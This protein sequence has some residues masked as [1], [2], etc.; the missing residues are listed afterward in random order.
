MNT[1]LWVC[2]HDSNMP[3]GSEVA[4]LDGFRRCDDWHVEYFDYR[5]YR[6]CN[7]DER[8]IEQVIIIK[9][10]AVDA[11]LFQRCEGMNLNAICDH[12]ECPIFYFATES[13]ANKTQHL[14]FIQLNGRVKKVFARKK[15]KEQAVL[16]GIPAED[17]VEFILPFNHKHYNNLKE[18]KKFDLMMSGTMSGRRKG[19][20]NKLLEEVNKFGKAG[21]SQ[22]HSDT[23]GKHYNQ[24][25]AVANVHAY[26][27]LDTE[28]RVFEVMS[29]SAVL[30]TEPLADD[31]DL[32]GK[33]LVFES[34]NVEQC[35]EHVKY[36]KEHEEERLA[37]VEEANYIAKTRS[38]EVCGPLM[39]DIIA[40]SL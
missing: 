19:I 14:S 7:V 31:I 6:Q 39:L 18:E 15:T 1:L 2:C 24:A 30:I 28:T 40:E 26:D 17:V 13:E 21:Y 3:W 38:W 23:L 9:A 5:V 25:L 20:F 33:A 37:M 36:L 10:Q 29:T 8:A 11:V 12:I 27:C 22:C 35:V 4:M 32:V 34:D 16:S